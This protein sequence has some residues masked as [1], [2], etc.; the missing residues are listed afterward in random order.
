V[1][2]LVDPVHVVVFGVR[3]PCSFGACT[4]TREIFAT[5]SWS[6]HWN[7][8]LTAFGEAKCEF[9]MFNLHEVIADIILLD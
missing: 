7:P 9:G 8:I 2:F 1:L 6:M 3:F 4:G 5:Q